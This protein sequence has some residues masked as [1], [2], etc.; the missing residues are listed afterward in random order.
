MENEIWLYSVLRIRFI[1][2]RLLIRSKEKRNLIQPKIE[3]KNY[4]SF[5][6]ISNDKII[7]TLF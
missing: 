2:I 3:K 6:N 7:V 5:D 4:F 1:L